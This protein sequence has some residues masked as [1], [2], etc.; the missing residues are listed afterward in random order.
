MDDAET[1]VD[2]PAT[3]LSESG[4]LEFEE[5]EE[6]E[7]LAE[8]DE[9]PAE[10]VQPHAE[11]LVEAEE[12]SSD[13]EPIEPPKN[14]VEVDSQVPPGLESDDEKAKDSHKDCFYSPCQLQRVIAQDRK[15]LV[16]E[17]PRAEES[18]VAAAK[19]QIEDMKK[20][21]MNDDEDLL[22]DWLNRL[23]PRAQFS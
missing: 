9:V 7:E 10:A 3:Q 19:R 8:D 14:V 1:Q 2:V 6:S 17:L 4:A 23:A 5:G 15:P 13:D 21:A 11:M 16:A 22:E 20:E 18:L 12:F